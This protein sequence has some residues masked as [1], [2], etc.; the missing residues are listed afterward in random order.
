VKAVI[1]VGGEGS[2]L[3]PLTYI[4]PKAMMPVLNRPFLEHTIAYLKSYQIEDIILTV[5]YLPD[6]IQEYFGNGSHL[7][8]R[9]TYAV[10]ANPLGTAGA[11]KNVEPQLNGTLVVLNG[12]IFT[13]LDLA[14]MCAFHQRHRAKVTI[15]LTWVDNTSAF[16]VVETDSRKRV[17]RFI[18]KPSPGQETTHWINAGIYIMEPEVL[19]HVPADSFYMFEKGLFPLLLEQ[20]E[21]V[22]GYPFH[23]YWLDMGTPEKYLQLNC[24]LLSLE[25]KSPLLGKLNRGEIRAG[26]AAIH[27]S[28]EVVGPAVIG[29]G[30]SISP[31]VHITGPVVIGP[32]CHVGESA[33]I[34]RAV[35]WSG[36]S[37]DTGANLKECVI[38]KG[39]ISD[40]GNQVNGEFCLKL[41]QD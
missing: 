15:A 6:V 25:T 13:D 3:R 22:Y 11:V 34:D 37:V 2:R 33:K 36:V 26:G 23:G 1:L 29:S 40:E 41:G 28:A 16:G 35:I 20:G 10:E 18:E 31:G 39:D 32:D 14:V 21:P 12:D 5:S 24:D 27:P 8:V 38:G 17:Q 4:I 30:C 7:G 19:E 9:L